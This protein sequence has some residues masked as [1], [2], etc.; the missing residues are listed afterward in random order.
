[1]MFRAGTRPSK[2]ARN[3]RGLIQTGHIELSLHEAQGP[4]QIRSSQIGMLQVRIVQLGSREIRC[5]QVRSAELGF[6]Q[7][8]LNKDSVAEVGLT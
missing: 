2:V 6:L 7:V 8:G 1:M 3:G 5:A 4:A